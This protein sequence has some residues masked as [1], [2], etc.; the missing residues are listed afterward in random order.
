MIDLLE[1]GWSNADSEFPAGLTP[2]RV[3]EMHRNLYKVVCPFGEVNAQLKGTFLHQATEQSDL[4]AVGDFV[5]IQLRNNS[6]AGI[7]HLLPR[8]SKFSRTDYSGKGVKHVKTILEQVIA[9]NFDFVFILSSLNQDLNINRITRY[10]TLTRIS[11]GTPVIVL[12]KADLSENWQQQ[13]TLVKESAKDVTVVA[14][15]S[16]TGFGMEQLQPYL[17]PGKTIVLLGMS[18][19]GKSTLLNALAGEEHM[20]V[21][22]I[23]ED[24]ARGRH[25]TTHRQLF[26]LPSGAMIIDTPGLR[27]VGL[28]ESDEGIHSGFADVED[29]MRQC[30][31]SNCKHVS[32]PGCAVLSAI[33]EGT[34]SQNRWKDYLTQTKEAAFVK[35]KQKPQ[36]HKKR[37]SWR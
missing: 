29:L 22:E 7:V 11:G 27:E 20:S 16:E 33:S 10:L 6:T 19:V 17:Q 4:P 12:T 15:S 28:W 26:K 30:Y 14:L 2:A 25:T 23:R 35:G 1:Y 21:K 37:K 5:L 31:F 3:T 32:E 8:R 13:L 36:N 34:L 24:D 9:T 18:G